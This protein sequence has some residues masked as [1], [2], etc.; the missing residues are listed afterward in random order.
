MDGHQFKMQS[1]ME[2]G[3]AVDELALYLDT[4][5][6]CQNG[7]S[8]F[9]EACEQFKSRRLSYELEYGPLCATSAVGGQNW[10]WV[11]MPWPW[12]LED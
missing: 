6:C 12:E 10:S 1:V 4:H 3:F 9:S 2:S 5:P 8:A 7:L 11:N